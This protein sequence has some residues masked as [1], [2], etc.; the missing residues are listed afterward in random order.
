M[1][2]G[3]EKIDKRFANTFDNLV[4]SHMNVMQSLAS[5]ITSSSL[6][7]NLS[8]QVQVAWRFLNNDY[9]DIKIENEP[10]LQDGVEQI[11]K[12]NSK[13]CLLAHDWSWINYKKHFSKEELWTRRENNKSMVGY[14]LQSS[15]AL[16]PENGESIAPL[17]QN[18]KTSRAIYSTYKDD[19]PKSKWYYWTHLQELAYRIN[20][21]NSL[22]IVKKIINIIDREA[23]SVGFFRDLKNELFLVR[24]R[25]QPTLYWLEKEKNI[26]GGD[27]SEA[28]DYKKI[29][30]IKYNH[31][32][33][34]LYGVEVDV[35]IRRKQTID[36]IIDGKRVQKRIAGESI[37]VRFIAAKLID[38]SGKEDKVISTWRLLTNVDKEVSL[39]ELVMWYYFRWKI[40]NFFKLLKSS[41]HQLESWQQQKPQAIF[42]RLIVVS[43]A[44]VLV[45]KLAHDKSEEGKNLRELL[46]KLSGR[47]IE[48]GK[49]FTYPA[50][51]VGL[52]NLLMM[53]DLLKFYDYNDI[54]KAKSTIDKIFSG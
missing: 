2:F 9:V 28:L 21:I 46:V 13:Y 47:Q 7:K 23:D 8:S 51:F 38:K 22:G 11:N 41:G 10:I 6:W 53:I 12:I 19:D 26:N 48:Y 16:N 52:W 25:T 36:R 49:E 34:S 15:L 45:W 27:L 35:E 37:K 18:L 43:Y 5:G 31:K 54:E 32:K 4:K 30:D 40:E 3:L 29:K 14:E 39:A 50:L 44:C 33:M 17:V 42:R 20:Y 24:V 1:L